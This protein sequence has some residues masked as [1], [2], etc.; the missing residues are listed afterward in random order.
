M[1]NNHRVTAENQAGFSD[2][3]QPSESIIPKNN[4]RVVKPRFIEGLRDVV[5]KPAE[6]VT[7]FCKLTGQPKPIVKWY[8]GGREVQDSD[9]YHIRSGKGNIYSLVISDVSNDDEGPFTVRA[10]NQ[11][12][13]VSCTVTL[14][15][16]QPA[17][18]LM[19]RYAIHC[20]YSRLLRYLR[21]IFMVLTKSFLHCRYMANEPVSCRVHQVATIKIPIEGFPAPE[22][23]WSKSGKII[24]A[25]SGYK[26]TSMPSATT[27]MI[28]DACRSDSGFYNITVKNR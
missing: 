9:K 21:S 27:L 23:Q 8:Q 12:G 7:L 26:I 19:P 2:P 14:T 4:V 1:V 15:V 20:M 11:G 17:R 10:T 25:E 6:N 13:S 16:K 22:V 5:A 24:T 28:P 3:S 18:V